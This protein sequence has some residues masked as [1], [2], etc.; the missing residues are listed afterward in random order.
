MMPYLMLG[1]H[2]LAMFAVTADCS[3]GS[4]TLKCETGLPAVGGSKGV[5]N[6]QVG[7]L[8]TIVFGV[9]AAVA[10]LMIVIAG[11]RLVMAQGNPQEIAKARNTIVYALIGL[12]VAL[13]AE[14]IVAFALGKV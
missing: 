1:L 6:H 8:L 2:N 7:Q 4:G 12:V 11:F 5:S 10:V 14:A 9:I 13:T 3:E